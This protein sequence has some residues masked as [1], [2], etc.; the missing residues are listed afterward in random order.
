MVSGSSDRRAIVWDIWIAEGG[1][2]RAEVRAVLKGHLDGVLDLRVD[3]QWI[4]SW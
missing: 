1:E 3:D 2:V 4:V